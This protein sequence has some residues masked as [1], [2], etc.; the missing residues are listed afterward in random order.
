MIKM[1]GKKWTEDEIDYLLLCYED[2]E[3]KQY[4]VA[5]F[6]GR[7]RN[8]VNSKAMQLKKEGILTQQT[9]KIPQWKK[10]KIAKYYC[11][12]DDVHEFAKEL[13]YHT[14][15]LPRWPCA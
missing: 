7:T 3:S 1:A 5:D 11:Y 9:I 13:G 14:L 15:Q 12:V 8:S 10:D 6:L 4:E 2:C